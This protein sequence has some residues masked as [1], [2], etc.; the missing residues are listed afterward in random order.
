[1][2]V[3]WYLTGPDGRYPWREDG[4]RPLNYAYF[5]QV[6]R[7]VDHL[8]FTGALLATGAHDAWVLGS[9]LIP[10][11]DRFQFLVAVHPPLVSP[12][13]LAKMAA[14]FDQFSGG[15]LRINIVNGDTK[16]L[17]GYG[18]HLGHDERYHY[19]DEWLTV[20]KQLM[21]G[22]T[23]DFRGRYVDVRGGSLTLPPVQKPAPPLWFG[24]SSD[25]ALDVAAKHIDTYLTWGETPVAAK[26]KI[27][28]LR[29]RA[30]AHGREDLKFG[31]RLYVVVRETEEEAWRAAQDLYDHMD[32]ESVAR[33]QA[34]VRGTDS[35]GQQRM[36]ALHGGRKPKD[37]RELEVYPNL[38]SGIGL[39][40]NG[41][42]TAI[43]GNPEQVVERIGEYRDAGVDTF[44]VSGMPLL[45]EAYRV[46]ELV[47]PHL[48][49]SRGDA[50]RDGG[51]VRATWNSWTEGWKK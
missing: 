17:A 20:F 41:P 10:Y 14:T 32:D 38:W 7:A 23:V 12:T 24:G 48:P 36:S 22:E 49:V 28:Q 19:S 43:V 1:M 4:A 42:G 29:E 44:I 9:S 39:V 15:R 33:T 26:E 3:L 37:L 45:E 6:A 13:L 21:A 40:R 30:A 34:G 27:A 11:T 18:V 8:G 2:D 46:G 25:A 35:V 47:L 31:V 16:L 5:Q 51:D 50:P